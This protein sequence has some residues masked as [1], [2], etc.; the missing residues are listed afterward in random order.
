MCIYLQHVLWSRM[1]KF[2]FMTFPPNYALLLRRLRNSNA[3]LSRSSNTS[4][5]I[6]IIK[7]HNVNLKNVIGTFITQQEAQVRIIYNFKHVCQRQAQAP[8][9]GQW[10]RWWHV[11]QCC[12]KRLADAVTLTD[13]KQNVRIY[14]NFFCSS[15]QKRRVK[16]IK[17]GPHLPKSSQNNSVL[18]FCLTTY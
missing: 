11:V 6:S 15:C 1:I 7:Q 17:V 18:I 13:L 9:V 2:T 14:F 3:K 12:A 10:K 4:K 8:W 5:Y 16:I